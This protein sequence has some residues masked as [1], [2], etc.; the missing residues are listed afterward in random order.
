MKKI[1][2][3]L[4]LLGIFVGLITC[5]P[6]ASNIGEDIVNIDIL[7]YSEIAKI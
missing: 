6:N 5:K 1:I 4:L 7:Y 3:A 2:G